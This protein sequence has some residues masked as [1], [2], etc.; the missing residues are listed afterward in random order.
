MAA[1]AGVLCLGFLCTS[2]LLVAAKI[3]TRVGRDPAFDFTKV[4]TWA[5]DPTEAGK[6]LMARAS[7]DDPEAIRKRFEPAILAAVSDELGKVGVRPPTEG[8]PDVHMHYYVAVTVG[9]DA[10]TMGQ[11]LPAVPMWGPVPFTAQTTSHQVTQRGMLVLDALAP[12]PDRVVWRGT[13]QT[14]MD[15]DKTDAQARDRIREVVRQLVRLYP[16][17]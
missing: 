8:A 7:G 3:E 6:F 13:A 15:W 16:R 12:S 4:H 5:W 10:Q 2:A 17:K 11:F 1:A 9:I 14:N